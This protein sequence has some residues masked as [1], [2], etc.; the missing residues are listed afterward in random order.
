MSTALDPGTGWRRRARIGQ[1]AALPLAVALVGTAA[2]GGTSTIRVHSGDTLS[3]IAVAHHTSV[4]ILR[5]LNHI[6]Q[7][8]DLILVGQRLLIPAAAPPVSRTVAVAKPAAEPVATTRIITYVVRSGDNLTAIAA[9]YKVTIAAVSLRNHLRKDGMIF[10]GQH[11]LIQVPVAVKNAHNSFAGRLYPPA[12]VAAA[13]RHRAYLARHD[14]PSTT[15]TRAMIIRTAK[16]WG[17]DPALALAIGWQESGF[18][19]RVVSPADAIGVMQV[20]PSTG[21]YISTYLAHRSLDLLNP[22]QNMTA[23]VA[24]LKALTD[25]APLDKAIAGYYQGLGSVLTRGMYADTKAYVASV[26]RLRKQFAG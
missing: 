16:R 22:Q 2:A 3:G 4:D 20:V 14:Q 13:D 5:R 24:L 6:A 18:Q 1:L 25:A 23:G 11:L 8:S 9:H 12:T 19:Q 21:A 15:Q 10:I 26:L 17:L 7:D